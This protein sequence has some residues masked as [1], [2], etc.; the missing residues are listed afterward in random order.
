MIEWY[1]FNAEVPSQDFDSQLVVLNPV[2]VFAEFLYHYFL[3]DG[4]YHNWTS[5]CSKNIYL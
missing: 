5:A 1:I 4:L 3:D 2:D